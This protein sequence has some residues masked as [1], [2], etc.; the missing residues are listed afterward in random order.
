MELTIGMANAQDVV[1]FTSLVKE[2]SYL[3][4]VQEMDHL[5]RAAAT[6]L[7][8][9]IAMAC[10]QVLECSRHLWWSTRHKARQHLPHGGKHQVL[11]P[12]F[13]GIDGQTTNR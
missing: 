8:G 2:M 6:C 4:M 12:R 3:L 7:R 10:W 11:R 9:P 1:A 13:V 5:L